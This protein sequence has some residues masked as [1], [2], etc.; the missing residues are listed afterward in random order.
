MLLVTAYEKA[1]REQR[2]R[3]EISQAKREAN[4][5]LQ[6]VE[7]GKEIAAIEEKN[8]KKGKVLLKM[9]RKPNS[10][11]QCIVLSCAK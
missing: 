11:S 7:K 6:S 4:I 9:V 1:V 10:F 3:T 5:Y 8:R 2:M